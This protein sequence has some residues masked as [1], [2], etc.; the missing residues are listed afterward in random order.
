MLIPFDIY[1][2]GGD[3]LLEQLT[4]LFRSIWEAGKTSRMHLKCTCTRRRETRH[5][6]TITLGYHSFA[7]LGRLLPGSSS[8]E[9]SHTSLIPYSLK[10]SAD[11]EQAGTP[12]TCFF[13]VCQLQEKCREHDQELKLVFL[14]LT[15]GLDTVNPL[16]TSRWVTE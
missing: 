3:L 16:I 14:D 7:V 15:K 12:A 9:S 1:K 4:S 2:N 10:C 11:F 5:P 8:T 6:V 13:V